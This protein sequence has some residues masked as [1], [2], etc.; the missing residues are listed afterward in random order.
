MGSGIF[1]NF[2]PTSSRRF[3]ITTR[4]LR[5]LCRNA[6]SIEEMA[7][8]WCGPERSILVSRVDDLKGTWIHFSFFFRKR[9]MGSVTASREALLDRYPEYTPLDETVI[10]F[11]DQEGARPNDEWFEARS[12][13]MGIIYSPS[14]EMNQAPASAIAELVLSYVLSSA[15]YAEI[16]GFRKD[17]TNRF[18]GVRVG[19]FFVGGHIVSGWSED[20]LVSRPEILEIVNLR[21][22]DR[23]GLIH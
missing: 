23:S 11:A 21:S 2:Q 17:D 1:T 13:R 9:L 7:L 19:L 14:H 3:L 5:Q 4:Q 12:L 15:G 10:Q 6:D 18:Q 8:Y 22:R 16:K 20:F